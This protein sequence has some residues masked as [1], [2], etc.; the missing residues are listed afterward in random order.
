MEVKAYRFEDDGSIPNNPYFPVLLYK[1]AFAETDAIQSTFENNGWGNSWVNGVFDYHHYH[2][3]TH[4]VL[5]VKSGR[6]TVQLGGATGDLVSLQAGDILILP[7]G[8]GHRRLEASE[9]FAI[10]GAYPDGRDYDTLTG[11]PEERPDSVN[12]IE[13]IAKPET[14]PVFGTAGPLHTEWNKEETT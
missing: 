7:A 9:D 6:A 3:N 1:E 2:S 14:D 8:T 4:E 5:G 12:R 13:T 11:N 10:V